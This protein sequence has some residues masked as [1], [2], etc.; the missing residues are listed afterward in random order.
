MVRAA[1]RCRDR[2]VV[3]AVGQPIAAEQQAIAVFEAQQV[4]VDVDMLDGPAERV[5]QDVTQPDMVASWATARPVST[6]ICA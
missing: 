5:D 4:D 1:E 2:V 3:D 6:S